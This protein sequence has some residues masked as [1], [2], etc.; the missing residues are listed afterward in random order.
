[1]KGREINPAIFWVILGVVIVGVAVSMW[2]SQNP[3]A[4]QVDVKTISPERLEDP[5][6][7]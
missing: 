1:M 2:V 4:Q 5:D 6:R 3:N 7:R